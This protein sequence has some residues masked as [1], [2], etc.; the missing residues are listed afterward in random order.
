[1]HFISFLR[2]L[3]FVVAAIPSCI[4]EPRNLLVSNQMGPDVASNFASAALFNPADN[5]VYVTGS[6]YGYELNSIGQSDASTEFVEGS[7]RCFLSTF[8]VL[9]NMWIQHQ[10]FGFVINATVAATIEGPETVSQHCTDIVLHKERIFLSGHAGVSMGGPL[11]ALYSRDGAIENFRYGTIMELANPQ[12]NTRNFVLKG[13]KTLQGVAAVYPLSLT[14]RPSDDWIYVVSLTTN[15]QRKNIHVVPPIDPNTYLPI[16]NQEI[17]SVEAFF[18]DGNADDSSTSPVVTLEKKAGRNFNP[19]NGDPVYVA[20]IVRLNDDIVVVAGYTQGQG[21]GF[22]QS[23]LSSNVDEPSPTFDG[24]VT[25]LRATTLAPVDETNHAKASTYRLESLNRGDETII[26]I[27]HHAIGQNPDADHIYIV[28]STTGSLTTDT[29]SR[30]GSKQAYISKIKISSMELVWA[31]QYGLKVDNPNAKV[32]GV[33][34]VVSRDGQY[35]WW[36]GHV[37]DGGVFEGAN[38]DTSF[39]KTDIFVQ[40]LL[41]ENGQAIV[42]R[43]FGSGDDDSIALRGGLVTDT[44]GNVIVV[45]NTQGSLQR[46]KNDA[47]WDV[48]IISVSTNGVVGATLAGETAT[49]PQQPS[50]SQEPPPAATPTAHPVS[51]PT[52]APVAPPVAAPTPPRPTAPA[53]SPSSTGQS[54]P[55][56]PTRIPDLTVPDKNESRPKSHFALAAFLLCLSVMV[57]MATA[58]M[59]VHHHNNSE[60][61]T[62]RVKVLPYLSRFDVEDVDL[63]HSATGGW[64]CSYANDLAQGKLRSKSRSQGMDF[65]NDQA[66]LSFDP[67]TAP[68]TNTVNSG[69][70]GGGSSR[71]SSRSK[72]SRSS[73]YADDNEKLGLNGTYSDGGLV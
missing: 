18:S 54:G 21:E 30:I 38:I 68:L 42:T 39:G 12:T 24:F 67:L 64:H 47:F 26:A 69:R 1:M 16:G 22:G 4:A 72:L 6:A 2:R 51:K 20:G 59:F 52:A 8:D 35:V 11:D 70:G 71:G 50:G 13:G 53:A 66:S 23:Y 58:F 32:E 7:H 9:K 45:G 27:C 10:T 56:S 19:G 43:Q 25:K 57:A 5:T 49:Q 46:A 14:T 31:K 36:S 17:M 44:D 55:T 65:L 48:F 29:T 37:S 60:A 73:L 62:D 40:R 15:S 61:I 33:S 63:K 28:G 34:C 41:A 3:A